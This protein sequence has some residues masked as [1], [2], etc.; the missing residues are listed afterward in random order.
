MAPSK[1]RIGK[2]KQV[3]AEQGYL[4]AGPQQAKKRSRIFLIFRSSKS[5]L[6]KI[7]LSKQ[8]APAVLVLNQFWFGGVQ[9]AGHPVKLYHVVRGDG[10]DHPKEIPMLGETDR[11][12]SESAEALG[13]CS[14]LGARGKQARP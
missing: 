8:A 14:V 13:C 6:T 7:R 10:T 11:I 4:T 5:C 2:S 1:S 9:M 12:I 3:V